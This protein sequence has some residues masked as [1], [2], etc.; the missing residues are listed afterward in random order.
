MFKKVKLRV[1]CSLIIFLILVSLP[2]AAV[3]LKIQSPTIPA[4]LPFLWMEDQAE[5]P[6]GVDLDINLSADHQRGI[7]LLAQNELD[8]LLTGTNL[9]ANAYL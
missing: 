1:I 8:F 9:G 6:A 5:L 2:A 7:S 3:E 4:V